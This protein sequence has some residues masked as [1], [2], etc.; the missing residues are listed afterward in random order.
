MI[1]NLIKLVI[2]NS[3]EHLLCMVNESAIADIW[4]SNTTLFLTK[5]VTIMPDPQNPGQM[6]FME[7][8]QFSEDDSTDFPCSEIRHIV[9]PKQQLVD[10][11]SERYGTIVV[12]SKIII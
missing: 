7:Y 9:Q 5:P 8:L 12:P 10:I 2:M 11:Y 6:V 1:M 4:R 3:G